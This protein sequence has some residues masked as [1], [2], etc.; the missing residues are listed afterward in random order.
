MMVI[1]DGHAELEY[2]GNVFVKIDDAI[3]TFWW[4]HNI[5][6]INNVPAKECMIFTSI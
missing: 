5:V 3:A 1:H 6:R 2:S 4:K